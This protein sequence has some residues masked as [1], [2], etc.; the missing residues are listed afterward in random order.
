MLFRSHFRLL[1]GTRTVTFKG[2]KNPL[3]R[4]SN[5]GSE[6]LVF[7]EKGVIGKLEKCI[8]DW[9]KVYVSKEKGWVLKVDIWGVGINELRN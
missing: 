6:I 7:A 9:C 3:H 1:S 4:R 5:E 2:E 8:K